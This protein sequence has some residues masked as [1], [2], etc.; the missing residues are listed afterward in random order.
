M[1]A[2]TR[3]ADYLMRDVDRGRVQRLRRDAAR[4]IW[5]VARIEGGLEDVD[6]LIGVLK[7]K[8]A[9]TQPY[10]LGDTTQVTLDALVRSGALTRG[11]AEELASARALWRRLLTIEDLA[12]W[13]GFE[14]RAPSTRLARLIAQ[15]AGVARFEDV[16][17]LIRGHAERVNLLYNHLMLGREKP[18]AAVSGGGR[19]VH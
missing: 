19:F 5:D 3:R 1:S 16:E 4:S 14:A 8:Y 15:A 6:L 17:P 18:F 2:G 13:S 9:A 11:Y 12:G 10:V 7:K